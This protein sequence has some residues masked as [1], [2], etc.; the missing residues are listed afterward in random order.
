MASVILTF[1]NYLSIY[2]NLRN[3]VKQKVY[4][5]KMRMVLAMDVYKPIVEHLEN[6]I[7]NPSIISIGCSEYNSYAINI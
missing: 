4:C 7:R 6:K 2:N 5:D 3:K 1:A